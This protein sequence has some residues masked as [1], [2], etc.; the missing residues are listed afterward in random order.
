MTTHVRSQMY[1]HTH[2]NVWS[3]LD[4]VFLAIHPEV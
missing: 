1:P 4:V 3:T 2:V